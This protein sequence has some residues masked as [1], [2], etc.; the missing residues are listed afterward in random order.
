MVNPRC[1]FGGRFLKN[2]PQRK[3]IPQQPRRQRSRQSPSTLQRSSAERRP[4]SARPHR[5]DR[6]VFG[7][8]DSYRGAL[9][10]RNFR[11]EVF[12]RNPAQPGASRRGGYHAGQRVGLTLRRFS[13]ILFLFFLFIPGSP[14]VPSSLS[15][16]QSEPVWKGQWDQTT[17]AAKK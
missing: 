16:A 13:V 2:R 1:R 9:A 12:R 7:F 17:T 11:N 6:I 10:C 8:G 5:F 14:L 4:L 3:K 15:L